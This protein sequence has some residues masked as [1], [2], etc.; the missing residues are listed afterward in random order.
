MSR[1]G[2]KGFSS[3]VGIHLW[4]GEN[5]TLLTENYSHYR[6]RGLSVSK[7]RTPGVCL[8]TR[9]NNGDILA[10]LM[11]EQNRS[12]VPCFQSNSHISM[13]PYHLKKCRT[14]YCIRCIVPMI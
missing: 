9:E 5:F 14:L 11:N 3:V 2:G 8:F 4:E 6:A 13:S 7:L 1:L 12:S 10:G